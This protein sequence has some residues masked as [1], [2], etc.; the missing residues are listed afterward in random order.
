MRSLMRVLCLAVVAVALL[1][2]TAAGEDYI[3]RVLPENGLTVI[4]QENHSS[5]VVNLRCYVRA[6]SILEEKYLGAGIS[7]YIEHLIGDETTTRSMEQ[8][9]KEV[10][11]IGGGYNAYTTKD[12]ACYFIETSHE[13]F[14][15][16]LDILVDQMMNS[17]MPQ[18]AVDTQQGIITREINMGYD[19]P[20]RRLY[21]LYGETMFRVHPTKY[22]TIGHVQNFLQLTRDDVLDYYTRMYVPNNM[23]FVAVGDLDG[24]EAYAKIHEAFRGYERKPIELPTLPSEPPQLGR[25]ELREQRDLD[26][27]YVLM[28]FH[29][30]AL[31]HPDLYPLDILSF[32]L[33]E[34]NSSRLYRKL[35]DELGLVYSVN[36]SSHTP[37]YDAGNFSISM[38]LD[39][40]NVDEAIRVVTQEIYKLRKERVTGQELAKAKKLKT[41]DFYF[42]MQDMESIASSLGT[43]EL[44]AG[45][46]DFDRRYAERIQDVTAEEI[47]DAVRKYF[48]DENISVA[49]LEPT[50]E[51]TP[52]AVRAADTAEAAKVQRRVLPNGLTVLIKEN[53]T[54]PVVSIGSY[55]LAGARIEDPSKAGAANFVARMLPHGTKKM[56]G[57]QINRELDSMGASFNCGANH[58]RIESDMTVLRED[59]GKGLAILA[60]MLQNPKFDPAEMEKERPLIQAQLLARGDD[61]NTDAMDR[62]LAELFKT[63]PYG[64][65]PVGSSESVAALTGGDLAA[66]HA[67]HVTPGNT[68]LTVF[69]DVDPA[70]TFAQIEKAFK[71]W[72]PSTRAM[73]APLSEPERTEPVR[74]TSNHDRAQTVIFMGYQGMPYASEDR[75]A[76]D[77]LDGIISGINYPG[78]WLHTDLRGNSLVYV[79]H[80]YNWTGIDE[81]YF[82]LYAATYDEALEQALNIIDGHMARIATDLVTDEELDHAKQLCTI[83]N[84]TQR[85]TNSSQA[86]DAAISELYGLGYG[87]NENYGAKIAA[88]TKE[89]VLRV[90]QKYLKNPV[91]IL[92][93]PNPPEERIEEQS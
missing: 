16:A 73:P 23:V 60:D 35:V 69:G 81:G 14:D 9:E 56:S 1:A 89:D 33:S 91:M 21:N 58:T 7:H 42:G 22:P 28:G 57:E 44:T 72:K 75:Y 6:G 59:F 30:V 51:G 18:E 79:V 12:H 8:M 83:M 27:A 53:H 52:E 86:R 13:N 4:V 48:Y 65:C 2:G 40:A 37:A 11:S 38:A 3:R 45:T 93:R 80:A 61:W 19:E 5:P 15:K 43:S 90:A 70:A 76:M 29:T 34:G 31:S 20:G 84:E 64:R 32:I 50:R 85:Q 63:H 62:M 25:R 66:Y 17:T 82:G 41:A 47:Q 36:T 88:V 46:P 10:E 39:P 71:D 68:V 77:V 24:E 92:R 49:V 78:G 55:S 67:A 74:L 87:Y 54:S 26:M